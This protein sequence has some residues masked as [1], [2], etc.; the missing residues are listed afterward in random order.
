[1]GIRGLNYKRI[2]S[3]KKMFR[4]EKAGSGML[5]QPNCSCAPRAEIPQ[6]ST[7]PHVTQLRLQ[8]NGLNQ[9][10]PE[11]EETSAR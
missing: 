3:K 10:S 2:A 1:M 8:H 7:R 9:H 4:D 6:I 5:F 11:L